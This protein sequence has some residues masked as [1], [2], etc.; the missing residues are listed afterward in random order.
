MTMDTLQTSQ[1]QVQQLPTQ[2]N[3][4]TKVNGNKRRKTRASL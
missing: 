1:D 3:M 2:V 4:E